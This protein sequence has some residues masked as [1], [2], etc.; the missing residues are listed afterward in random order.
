VLYLTRRRATSVVEE[1]PPLVRMRRPQRHPLK[2]VCDGVRESGAIEYVIIV[3]EDVPEGT[4]SRL[5]LLDA[6]IEVLELAYGDVAPCRGAGPRRR[7]HDLAE[8]VE[9]EA[10]LAE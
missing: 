9:R 2:P 3:S 4:L 1:P 8:L 7:T 5:S 6:V 10:H